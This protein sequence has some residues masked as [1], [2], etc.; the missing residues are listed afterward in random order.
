MN[1]SQKKLLREALIA[2]LVIIIISRIAYSFQSISFL[3]GNISLIS[4]VLLLYVPILIH[5]RKKEKVGYLDW[6]LKD[7]SYSCRDFLILAV[8]IFP[9]AIVVNH[10]YQYVIGHAYGP[11][12]FPRLGQSIFFQLIVVALPEEF[13]FRGYL[14]GRLNQVFGR[15]WKFLR[16]QVGWGLIICSFLF[17]VSHS[18][19]HYQWWHLLIFFPAVAFGW[20]REKRG[21]I[22]API[23]FH[24]LSNI[25]SHWVGYHYF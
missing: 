9:I 11:A 25:F 3:A 8:C 2:W 13:F 15:P 22:T 10:G 4:A 12:S 17:A 21:T 19:I 23:L 1:S 24:T 18:L 7:I 5:I 20:L 14:Q 16:A 6:S